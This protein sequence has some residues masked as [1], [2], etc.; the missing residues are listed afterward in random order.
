MQIGR[1]AKTNEERWKS[2]ERRLIE[3]FDV[4][5]LDSRTQFL[6][7]LERNNAK[8]LRDI[9]QAS[10][11]VATFYYRAGFCAAHMSDFQLAERRLRTAIRLNPLKAAARVELAHVLT[12]Q[13]RFTEALLEVDQALETASNRCLKA[14]ILRRRGFIFVEMGR[15]AEARTAYL[16]SLSLDPASRIAKSELRTIDTLERN[17]G[18][19][20]APYNLG[21]ESMLAACPD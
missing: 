7:F 4:V 14:V 3:K 13:K 10:P 17:T 11:K 8:A 5:S 21:S 15:L 1:V 19:T 9:I 16:D 20:V 12:K 6:E 18:K 2:I